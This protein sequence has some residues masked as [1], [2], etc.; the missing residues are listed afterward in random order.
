VLK[1]VNREAEQWQLS[2]LLN[3]PPNS[4][5]FVYGPKSSGKSTLMMKVSD[6]IKGDV[7]Y[8][9][10]RARSPA[11][12][13]EIL[14]VATQTLGSRIRNFFRRKLRGTNAFDGI[15]VPASQLKLMSQG[16]LDPFV[17]LI[18]KIKM[19]KRPVLILDEIQNLKYCGIDSKDLTQLLNFLVTVTKR[20]H[21]AH[22]IVVT[23]DC[24]FI[25]E[26]VRQAGLEE[27]AE[28]LY[29]GDLPKPSILEWLQEE[30]MNEEKAEKVYVALGG[31]PFDIW[32]AIQHFRSTGGIGVL[33]TI[34]NRKVSRVKYLL[35]SAGAKEFRFCKKLSRESVPIED[36]D[37]KLLRWGIEN[38]IC[39]FDPV[40]GE[41]YPISQSMRN[42]LELL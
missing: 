42:A 22:A 36:I 40:N 18:N 12:L 2:N 29:V 26:M 25:D 37:T 33:D 6:S 32:V 35:K 11:N 31:R 5:L 17:P 38:E 28:F 3:A 21:I 10:F 13:H 7:V 24:L 20:L 41:I 1:F 15:E 19:M 14:T 34:V 9:D 23:S 16:R 30:G 8:Y 4:V 39:F 27:T